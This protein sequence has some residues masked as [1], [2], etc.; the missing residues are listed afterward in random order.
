MRYL[1]VTNNPP[2]APVEGVILSVNGI[3]LEY[4]KAGAMEFVTELCH[5]PV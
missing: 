4:R 1:A 5:N 2:V 3:T